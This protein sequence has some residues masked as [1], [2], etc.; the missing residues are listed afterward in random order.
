MSRE[1]VHNM[2]CWLTEGVETREALGYLSGLV[3]VVLLFYWYQN[4]GIS[5]RHL[6]AA[7]FISAPFIIGIPLLVIALYLI[8]STQRQNT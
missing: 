3:G 2:N 1:K 4:A 8:L 6:K 7:P 5:F